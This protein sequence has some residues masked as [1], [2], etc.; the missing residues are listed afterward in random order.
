[1]APRTSSRVVP[2]SSDRPG[3]SVGM[4]R[5]TSHRRTRPDAG[6]ERAACY[7]AP[8]TRPAQTSRPRR[9]GTSGR[10]HDW[11]LGP[12][13]AAARMATPNRAPV[14][15]S[16]IGG[17]VP[18]RCAKLWPKPIRL[19]L[20]PLSR[21]GLGA[22]ECVGPVNPP[23]RDETCNRT[24]PP[25]EFRPVRTITRPIAMVQLRVWDRPFERLVAVL[26][27]HDPEG[28][29]SANA[30]DVAP[31]LGRHALR[32]FAGVFPVDVQRSPAG[33]GRF[34]PYSCRL[35]SP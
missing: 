22:P 6:T 33:D 20:S 21:A 28:V 4:A 23:P 17:D 3:E 7:R 13:I 19:Y 30:N 8:L 32:C 10:P 9:S 31:P 11:P 24:W 5:T 29:A 16:A 25:S 14:G 35:S 26:A 27:Q 2:A 1:M 18:L 12:P 34:S 15:P